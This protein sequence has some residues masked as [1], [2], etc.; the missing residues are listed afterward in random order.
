M[1]QQKNRIIVKFNLLPEDTPGILD[2]LVEEI[3]S[4][5]PGQAVLVRRPSRSGRVVLA[6]DPSV[7]VAQLAADLSRNERVAYAE[8]DVTDSGVQGDSNMPHQHP[9]NS[10]DSG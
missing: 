7:D 1:T 6:V 5:I 9:S 8:P 4:D 2:R 3:I 10:S